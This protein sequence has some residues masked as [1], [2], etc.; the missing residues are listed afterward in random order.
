MLLVDEKVVVRD[1]H[2]DEFTKCVGGDL[3][4][5]SAPLAGQMPVRSTG[6][7]IDHGT[8]TEVGVCDE[9]QGIELVENAIDGRKANFRFPLP[10]EVGKVVRRWMLNT[11]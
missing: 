5:S 4:R 6:D 3:H 11:A 7:V 2:L 10:S 8:P 9:T 1:R